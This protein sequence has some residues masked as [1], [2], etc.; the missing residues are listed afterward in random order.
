MQIKIAVEKIKNMIVC[1]VCSSCLPLA[2]HPFWES[3]LYV[4][5]VKDGRHRIGREEGDGLQPEDS[6]TSILEADVSREVDSR[7]WAEER[8]M[9]GMWRGWWRDSLGLGMAL[10]HSARRAS[11]TACLASGLPLRS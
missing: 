3:C 11:A 4:A 2:H 8:R 6:A 7:G 1:I 5:W 9:T 10:R